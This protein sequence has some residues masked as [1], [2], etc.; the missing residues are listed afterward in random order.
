MP[1]TCE[2]YIPDKVFIIRL[3]GVI[4]AAD[5][6]TM[7]G[8]WVPIMAQYQGKLLHNITD[9]SEVEHYQVTLQNIRQS[10]AQLGSDK[11]LG[12]VIISGK[13][14]PFI[15]FIIATSSQLTGFKYRLLPSVDASIAFLKEYDDSLSSLNSAEE[16]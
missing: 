6:E 13:L 3:S 4:T 15:H 8:F 1:V 7:A 12:W 11:L 5:I 9:V 10:F 14:N 16:E 2:W